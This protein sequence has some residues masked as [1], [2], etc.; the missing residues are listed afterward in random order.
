MVEAND[1]FERYAASQGVYIHHYHADNSRFAD[2]IFRQAVARKGQTLS[3]C[4]VN[5]HFQNGV[6]EQR[7]RELQD[8][9]WCMLIHANKRWPTA[10][11]PNLWPYALRMANSIHNETPSLKYIQSPLERFT[12]TQVLPNPRYWHHFGA[13][14]YVLDSEVDQG[15]KFPKWTDRAR[16]GI[17]LGPAPQHARSVALVLSLTTGLTSP[18]LHVTID[19]SFQ[20]M[21]KAFDTQQPKSL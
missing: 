10:I 1:A 12:G 5:A 9:A 2:N 19:D 13:P 6:A 18:Q 16:V 8:H 7:I 3:F 11:T 4:G 21:R 20:T 14:A 17:Y 15:K